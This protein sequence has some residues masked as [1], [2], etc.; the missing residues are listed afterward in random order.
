VSHWRLMYPSEYLN[1]ADLHEKEIAA[2]IE[3][4]AIEEVPGADGT[5]K[6][7]PVVHFKGGKKRLPLPKCCAKVIA[8]A[9][10]KDTDNWVGKK[11]VLYPTTCMAFGQEVECV[12]VKI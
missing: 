10:G 4:V 2:I 3:R 8:A 11:I 1:A 7:K 5:K 9:H 12:R 6:A